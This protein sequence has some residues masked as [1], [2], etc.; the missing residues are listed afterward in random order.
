MQLGGDFAL[1]EPCQGSQQQAQARGD[2]DRIRA[3]FDAS[4][5]AWT[6]EMQH[7][8]IPAGLGLVAFG[9]PAGDLFDQ[10][11]RGGGSEAVRAEDVDGRHAGMIAGTLCCVPVTREGTIR[12]SMT[13]QPPLHV[14]YLDGSHADVVFAGT[15]LHAGSNI[16]CELPLRAGAA[17]RHLS[18]ERSDAG[19]VLTVVPGA[20]RVY[21][22]ARPVRER[23]LLRAGDVIGVGTDILLLKSPAQRFGR[24]VPLPEMRPLP[25][26]SASLI[27]LRVVA[28]P[29]YGRRFAID[30]GENLDALSLPGVAGCLR[31]RPMGGE[32]AFDFLAAEPDAAVP[33]CNGIEANCGSLRHDDQIVWGK[34][35]LVLEMPAP[36]PEP[37]EPAPI[38]EAVDTVSAGDK[39]HSQMWWLIA[40]AALIAAA[41]W[42]FLGV[43]S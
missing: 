40:T 28:G 38:V 21:V 31:L 35:R 11:A 17:D 36:V 3:D 14:G 6:L 43:R 41:I 20:A 2:A 18:I 27:G 39:S 4:V 42:V 34:H 19:I 12:V 29:L 22:N 8:A 15:V 32:V 37:I 13:E 25:A 16:G 10:T 30:G 33:C 1:D 5:D 26:G 9:K 23:A 7:I 24:H